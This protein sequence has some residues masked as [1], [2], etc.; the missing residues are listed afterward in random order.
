M[1]FYIV[2]LGLGDHR[3][4]T[5]KGLEAVR[6]CKKIYLESYT[7]I[8]GVK[9]EILEEFYQKPVIEADR[10]CCETGIDQILEGISQDKENNYA[11]LVVGDPFCATTHTDLY[12]RAVKLNIRVEVIHNASIIN[13]IGCTGLMVYRFG[14]VV[15]VPYFTERWRPYSFFPK[16]KKNLDHNLHTLVLLDI[17]VK[18]ISEENLARGKKIYEPP[19]FMKVSEAVEQ[20]IESDQQLGLHAVN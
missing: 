4:I 13:A 12:L 2:G 1:V 7:S 3:D 15:S 11:F 18:E 8:L 6:T 16:I 20:I 10:E 5:V 9:K 14:E 19:R 17:K